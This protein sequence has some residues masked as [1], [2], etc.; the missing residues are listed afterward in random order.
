MV[1]KKM[2][3]INHCIDKEDQNK[4]LGLTALICKLSS[5]KFGLF[6]LISLGCSF[7][8][9]T[10]M[11]FLLNASHYPGSIEDTQLGFQAEIIKN[12]FQQMS[13]HELN[14]Y[15][16]AIILD[17]GFIIGYAGILSL[18]SLIFI[19]N[20]G[21][22][23]FWN[24][25]GQTLLW[26]GIGSAVCDVFENLFLIIMITNPQDFMAWLAIAHSSCA[27]LKFILMSISGVWMVIV[28]LLALYQR[29][30]KM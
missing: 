9:A 6:F 22:K 13:S 30:S 29:F 27:L 10:S 26:I 20:F 1:F 18:V 11:F 28:L 3:N 7:I 24:K 19:R 8:F 12:Y 23:P 5:K 16:I 25:F 21:S 14:L 15:L 17:Y 2:S 4:F